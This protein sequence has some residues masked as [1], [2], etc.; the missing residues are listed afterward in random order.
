MAKS[1]SL[2]KINK[3]I[4]S[5]P[6]YKNYLT[7]AKLHLRKKTAND[8]IQEVKQNCRSKSEIYTTLSKKSES[9]ENSMIKK[10]MELGKLNKYDDSI[11]K[12]S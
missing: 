7:E 5:R 9:Y 6:V 12:E 1:F 11:K 10:I 8:E 4:M 3:D 2:P